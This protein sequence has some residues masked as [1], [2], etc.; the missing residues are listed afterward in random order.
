MWCSTPK[1]ALASSSPL[2]P[3]PHRVN[4]SIIPSPT[5]RAPV[6]NCQHRL[7]RLTSAP[8]LAKLLATTFTSFERARKSSAAE[9]QSP[10]QS[11]GQSVVTSVFFSMSSHRSIRFYALFGKHKLKQNRF[12]QEGLKVSRYHEHTNNQSPIKKYQNRQKFVVHHQ[13]HPVRVQS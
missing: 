1:P 11:V 5:A 6:P 3:F 7:F 2:S 12:L 8:P 9:Q 10:S 13:H 4:D